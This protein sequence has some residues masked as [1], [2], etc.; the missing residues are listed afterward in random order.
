MSEPAGI[1]ITYGGATPPQ[2]WL[3]CNGAA[4]SRSTYATLFS[5]I[6]TTYGDGDGSTTFNLPDLSGKV[7]IG[8]SQS[9]VLA[10]TGGTATE[11]LLETNLPVH[12]HDVPQHG[13][14]NNIE[15]A[16]PSLSHTVTQPGY[17]YNSPNATTHRASS[18]TT[19]HYTSTSTATASRS[20]N[21]A[22][23][24]HPATVCTSSGAIADCSA[25]ASST[26]QG[27]GS[28]HDNMQPYLSLNYIISTGE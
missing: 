21:L 7:A 20:A 2:G 3:I 4:V 17:T 14:E 22:I 5:V 1:V 25:M 13:H 28:S 19:T 10:S 6:G 26:S 24:N 9:H 27:G 16:T 15:V 12:T 18:Q 11:T 23:S 8:S